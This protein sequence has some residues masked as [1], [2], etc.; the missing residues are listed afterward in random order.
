MSYYVDSFCLY[1]M[2]TQIRVMSGG[3]WLVVGAITRMGG[4]FGLT[5]TN[6]PFEYHSHGLLH[7]NMM[8]HVLEQPGARALPESPGAS[9]ARF[10]GDVRELPMFG[11]WLNDLLG[12]VVNVAVALS[13]MLWINAQITLIVLA[14]LVLIAAIA[15]GATHRIQAYRS[16]RKAEIAAHWIKRAAQRDLRNPPM[17]F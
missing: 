2:E 11:L 14:P 3:L 16:R 4:A 15:N 12:L 5:R 13:I 1:F 6:R 8:G 7:K 10:R 17:G 9:I